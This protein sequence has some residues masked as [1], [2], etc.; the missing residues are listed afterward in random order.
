LDYR[1]DLKDK[2]K[3]NMLL[4]PD[5]ID[6]KKLIKVSLPS[7]RK[8]SNLKSSLSEPKSVA[9]RIRRSPR[10]SAV[11]ATHPNDVRSPLPRPPLPLQTSQELQQLKEEIAK[12]SFSASA[13]KRVGE[14]AEEAEEEEEEKEAVE[15]EGEREE[16]EEEEKEEEGKDV[17]SFPP[18]DSS[19][20]F[21]S[22]FQSSATIRD[23]D[24]SSSL[25]SEESSPFHY[26][27][28]EGL[29]PLMGVADDDFALF[30]TNAI[31]SPAPLKR[32][33]CDL[34]LSDT[35][36]HLRKDPKIE[37]RCSLLAS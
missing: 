8:A 13:E 25:F 35:D 24:P 37:P 7:S 14:E 12:P 28:G 5:E 32:K 18:C 27:P 9:R 16:E 10:S 29:D 3:L 31:E 21:D 30:T 1:Y 15:S 17:L 11:Q 26:V 36:L 2:V 4:V 34:W 23:D 22:Y 6:L 33:M 19:F 20:D